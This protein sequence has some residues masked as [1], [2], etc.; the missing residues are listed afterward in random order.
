[1]DVKKW[2]PKDITPQTQREKKEKEKKQ[3]N[4]GEKDSAYSKVL[5]LSDEELLAKAIRDLLKRDE[6]DDGRLH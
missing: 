4:F 5:K 1:M 3:V 6:I 2:S